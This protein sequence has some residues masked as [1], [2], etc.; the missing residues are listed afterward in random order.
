LGDEV[1]HAVADK[2]DYQIIGRDL[3]NLAAVRANVP[4]VA[5][6]A[7]DDL[8]LLD[9]HPPPESIHAYQNSISE[10]MHELAAGGNVVIVGRAGQVILRDNPQVLHVKVIAPERMRFQRVNS[11]TLPS[12]VPKP[13]Y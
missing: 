12:N 10:I 1:A 7:I 3:I 6:A 5:L 9:L 8:G 13:K 2:L 11:K 4:E